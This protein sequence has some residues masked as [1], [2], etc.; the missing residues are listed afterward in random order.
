[1]PL[2]LVGLLYGC[3]APLKVDYKPLSKEDSG[4]LVSDLPILI[5]PFADK[6]PEVAT[7]ADPRVVGSIDATTQ[8]IY[9]SRVI[10][11]ESPSVLITEGFKKYLSAS[12]Y[13]VVSPERAGPSFSGI[14][15][16]GEIREFRFDIGSRDNIEINIYA[17]FRDKGSGGIIWS[18]LALEKDSRYAG[19]FGDSRARVSKYISATLSKVF[20]KTIAKA[21]P[22]IEKAVTAG[23]G[24]G[25]REPKN[26]EHGQGRLI[27]RTVPERVSIYLNGVYYGLSPMTLR[28][29]PGIYNL[30]MSKE[31]FHEFKEKIAVGSGR[32]TE[33]ETTLKEK[34]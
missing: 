18:G 8:D 34:K 23:G 25:G 13:T 26:H 4:A 2:L 20:R 31:G 15:L 12:G 22:G 30:L 9:G 24:N 21:G 11:S 27:V 28:L 7:G 19:V 14:I 10:L 6:R 5:K 33:M 3:V 29:R 1:L 16:T 32:V 17:E